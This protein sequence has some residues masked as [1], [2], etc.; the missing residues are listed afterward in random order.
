MTEPLKPRIDFD[1]PL[2]VEKAQILKSARAFDG[3]DA[4]KF[5][6]AR[7]DAP[8][9]EEGAAEAVVES[10][11]RPKRSLW[12]KMVSAG[13]A[14]FGVSVVAQGVQWT[15]TAWQTQD[16]IALGG[17][18]AGALI[19]GAGVGSVATEW[20][21]LWRLRQRAHERDEARDLM[22]S[23]A[24]SKGRAFCE[25]LARQAGLD[26]SHPA[27]QRW[28]AA[29]HE[30]QN[31]REVVSLYAQIVQPVLDAQARREIS[32]SAAEST[33]MIAVSP[34]A[35]VDMA[36]IAWRNLRLINRIATLYGIELGYYSRLRLFRLV[37]LNIAFAGASELVREVGMDWMSQDLAA[38]LSA[39]AAQ[40]IGAGLLTARLG[41]KAMEVC[42]PLPW[43]DDD[44][45]RLGDFR[46]ELIGQLKETLNKKPAP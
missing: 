35:L 40:G 19:V 23:H 20:R 30:T 14:I 29:I 18:A 6:P 46:R 21:R 43:I 26:H 45:P 12:R 32:R 24:V 10:V 1:G 28:Y 11:L 34:L 8:E 44:K 38:R 36:F 5:A 7:L 27:L 16:W 33:L 41:I 13:L 2:E 17:C 9:E 37:L 42:R 3:A 22:H 4:E 25:K 15:M 31:D 39:R